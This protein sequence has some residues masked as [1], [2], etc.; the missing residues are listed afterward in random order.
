[1]VVVAAVV[2]GRARSGTA[3][4]AGKD[5]PSVVGT[6]AVAVG[7]V[8]AVVAAAEAF[9]VPWQLVLPARSACA[10]VPRPLWPNPGSISVGREQ[11][12]MKPEDLPHLISW[13]C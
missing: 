12:D 7:A 9:A 6:A 10:S 4:L 3:T 2:L 13:T 5:E 11:L 1:M 8:V